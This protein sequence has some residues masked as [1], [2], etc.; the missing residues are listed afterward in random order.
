MVLFFEISMWISVLPCL[1]SIVA[2]SSAVVDA[3]TATPLISFFPSLPA[4]PSQFPTRLSKSLSK[5]KRL[6]HRFRALAEPLA[7]RFLL[8]AATLILIKKRFRCPPP[9]RSRSRVFLVSPL[10]L[11]LLLFFFCGGRAFFCVDLFDIKKKGRKKKDTKISTEREYFFVYHNSQ[12]SSPRTRP[13]KRKSRLGEQESL[14][15]LGW[16]LWNQRPKH[17]K[18]RKES[19][20]KRDLGIYS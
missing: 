19:H 16:R 4:A 11:L 7:P 3:S 2:S 6:T 5:M 12:R 8:L 10:L 15:S 14:G 13:K 18:G 17:T 1:I 20:L 9:R